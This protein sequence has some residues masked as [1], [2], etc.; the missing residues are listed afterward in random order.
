[1]TYH[2]LCVSFV[3]FL[4]ET[5]AI[6]E[7]I[8]QLIQKVRRDVSVVLDNGLGRFHCKVFDINRS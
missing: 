2:H 7:I 1:M 6:F 3:P 4:L 5:D 8:R